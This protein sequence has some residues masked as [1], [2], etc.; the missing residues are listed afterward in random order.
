[1]LLMVFKSG[2]QA[3]AMGAVAGG[4]E[5]CWRV[6]LLLCQGPTSW[7]L[8]QLP[9]PLLKGSLEQLGAGVGMTHFPGNACDPED[10][11]ITH[12]TEEETEV[13]RNHTA[14]STVTSG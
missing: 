12:F 4:E 10:R 1:M 9:H 14:H 2:V 8:G 5:L 3:A 11:I 13:Q 7:G 6:L